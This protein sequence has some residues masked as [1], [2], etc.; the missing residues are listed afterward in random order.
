MNT[1]QALGNRL[2]GRAELLKVILPNQR[3]SRAFC[4]SNKAPKDGTMYA[5][6]TS[7]TDQDKARWELM[8][9]RAKQQ[10]KQSRRTNSKASHI[11]NY[12]RRGQAA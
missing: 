6:Y 5:G 8:K 3:P 11:T 2:A 4:F 1:N 10:A 9:K 7:T 12:N